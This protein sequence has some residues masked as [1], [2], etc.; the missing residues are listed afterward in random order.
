MHVEMGASAEDRF[1][2]AIIAP[3]SGAALGID[4]K[5]VKRTATG[6]RE[7]DQKTIFKVLMCRSEWQIELVP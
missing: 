3:D 2:V 6:A 4:I 7:Q 5:C 1:K